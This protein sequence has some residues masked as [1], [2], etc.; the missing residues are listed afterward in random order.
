[1]CNCNGNGF[2]NQSGSWRNSRGKFLCHNLAFKGIIC[3]DCRRVAQWRTGTV[4]P[5][6]LSRLGSSSTGY[7]FLCKILF[8]FYSFQKYFCYQTLF[9]FIFLFMK[10]FSGFRRNILSVLHS[11][12]L[13][14]NSISLFAIDILYYCLLE[15][16]Y[17]VYSSFDL[18]HVFFCN[19]WF[20]LFFNFI[21]TL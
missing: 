2:W 7:R 20:F 3:C 1:M 11:S 19:V 4:A 17:S 5:P 8:R 21:L 15:L 9:S 12:I 10:F 13:V 6:S 18:F 16:T 14:T